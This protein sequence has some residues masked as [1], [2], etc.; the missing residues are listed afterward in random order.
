MDRKQNMRKDQGD[1]R[2]KI[3]IGGCKIGTTDTEMEGGKYNAKNNEVLGKIREIGLIEKRA[4]AAEKAAENGER[5]ELYSIT[6]VT[7]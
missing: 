3:D 1:E 2:G 4:A 7:R 5:K 6:T